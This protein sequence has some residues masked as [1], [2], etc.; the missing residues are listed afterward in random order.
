MR[1]MNIQWMILSQL[2]RAFSHKITFMWFCCVV[3]GSCAGADPIGGVSGIVRNLELSGCAYYSMLRVFGSRAVDH[4][5]LAQ[6]WMSLA[7]KLFTS[8]MLSVAG[9]I[10]LIVDATKVS[11]TGR[12]MPG[13]L[14]MKD[15][16]NDGWMR[17]HYFES[18]AFVAR[19]VM[20][21]FPI[22]V[23]TTLQCGE[24]GEVGNLVDRCLAFIQKFPQVQGCLLVG[25]AWYS[26][27]KLISQLAKMRTIAMVTRV[28]KNVVAY[29]VHVDSPFEPVK[30][31][32]KKK[33]G[34]KIKLRELFSQELLTWTLKDNR[35]VEF[36]VQGWAR[37][38][39]W[40][41]LGMMVRFVGISHPEK[42][43]LVLMCS[44]VCLAPQDIAQAYVY[45]F[46]I[47]VA[48]HNAKSM[49]GSYT[50]R[51]W[52][53]SMDRL[54][55][56]P[57]AINLS[58]LPNELMQ[59]MR[60]KISSFELFVTAGMIAQGILAYLAINHGTQVTEGAKFWLRTKRG[61]ES[62][63][64]IAAAYVKLILRNLSEQTN[65]SDPLTKFLLTARADA[66]KYFDFR[67]SKA[68]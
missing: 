12:K 37:D 6:R 23:A 26:K 18:L 61:D 42:G 3:I 68:G 60:K 19:G 7:M 44:D 47:E 4:D 63:E 9:R 57:N 10:L 45:R 21:F 41:P 56:F 50:Y 2:Q 1:M 35:G 33:Y 11:K 36:E 52:L 14:G 24:V 53:K 55:K 32:R 31:G 64:R 51:F 48:F 59:K 8:N 34:A 65:Q 40:K 62:S 28:A 20:S 66:R 13:V 46:W 67:M 25:D 22:P 49:I 16:V 39:L 58:D 43:S 15:T 5:L 29:E 17:G 54:P 27:S 38:L 30:R